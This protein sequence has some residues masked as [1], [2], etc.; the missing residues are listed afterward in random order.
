[1]GSSQF[2]IISLLGSGVIGSDFNLVGSGPIGMGSMHSHLKTI[3]FFGKEAK[4]NM[5]N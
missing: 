1:M 3:C 2:Q 5:L 4:N